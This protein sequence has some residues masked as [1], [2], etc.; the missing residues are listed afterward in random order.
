MMRIEME[1]KKRK[2]WKHEEKKNQTKK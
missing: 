2:R 1:I